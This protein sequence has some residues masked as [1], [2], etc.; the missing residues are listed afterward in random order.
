MPRKKKS[1]RLK[2]YVRPEISGR[3][4]LAT[5]LHLMRDVGDRTMPVYGITVHQT[6]SSLVTDALKHGVDPLEYAGQFYFNPK[7]YFAH[8]V[9]GH[10]GT[11]AQIAD[12]HEWAMHVGL[13]KD[14]RNDYLSGKWESMLPASFVGMWKARWPG[15]KSPSHL[16]PG[17]SV[18]D[19][20][21]GM[22]ML[23]IVPG[24]KTPP[25]A[26]G[27]LFTKEQH[28]AVAKLS[29]DIAR[30]WGFPKGW[31][32][33]G[34]FATHEDLNPFNRTTVKPPAGWDPGVLRATPWFSW[35]S[36]LGSLQAIK[37][38]ALAVL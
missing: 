27:M 14:E 32:R 1:N 30:R 37:D 10:D 31:E 6:G 20:Y 26:P 7:N 22:E 23:P 33:T 21:V 19:A 29:W 17:N 13:T 12:E 5:P 3:S 9:I 25:L 18:N 11:I 28:Q 4:S 24:I 2:V 36:V 35:G 16:Y 8:Y 15:M 34:R 38:G